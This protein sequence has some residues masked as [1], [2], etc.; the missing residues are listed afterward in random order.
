L[1]R[2]PSPLEGLPSPRLA[3]PRLAA[4]AVPHPSSARRRRLFES[5]PGGEV[6]RGQLVQDTVLLGLE[7]EMPHEGLTTSVLMD[8]AAAPAFGAPHAH[9]E[10]H[11][12]WA[13]LAAACREAVIVQGR[14]ARV[15]SPPFAP[16]LGVESGCRA[17]VCLSSGLVCRVYREDALPYDGALAVMTFPEGCDVEEVRYRTD[18]SVQVVLANSGGRL[19]KKPHVGML[20]YED[21]NLG[22]TRWARHGP[23][24]PVSGAVGRSAS[25]PTHRGG[26]VFEAGDG[27]QAEAWLRG[28]GASAPTVSVHTSAFSASRGVRETPLSPEAHLA[29]RAAGRCGPCALPPLGQTPILA[30]FLPSSRALRG[31][32]LGDRPAFSG[33]GSGP[34]RGVG[35]VQ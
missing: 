11:V 28:E 18:E 16:E 7:T 5:R 15:L 19:V 14:G 2:A 33:R 21:E 23:H 17:M 13:P 35:T 8:W 30:P 25:R 26:A 29:Q 3:S 27:S 9:R 20:F 24:P 31:P 10:L 1:Q 34:R 12:S 22:N 6:D 32:A 4:M